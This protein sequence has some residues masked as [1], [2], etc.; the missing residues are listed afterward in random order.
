MF[1]K[2]ELQTTIIG[3]GIKLEGDF[4]GEGDLELH[5]V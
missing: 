3:E 4:S 5:G 2:S 1:E